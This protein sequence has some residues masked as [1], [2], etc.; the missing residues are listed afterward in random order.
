MA[1]AP[2]SSG[3]KLTLKLGPKS[4]AQ[5]PATPVESPKSKRKQAKK[6]QKDSPLPEPPVDATKPSKK[7]ARQDADEVDDDA[8][9]PPSQ[10]KKQVKGEPGG[11]F[12]IRV[13]TAPADKQEEKV[14]KIRLPPTRPQLL[15]VYTTHSGPVVP[16]REPGAGYDSEDEEVEKDPWVEHQFIVRMQ[17]GDDCEYL[18]R[19]VA[20]RSV[21]T[22]DCDVKFL[23]FDRDSGR[24]A[25]VSVRGNHYAAFLVD[26][27]C[28]IENHKSWDKKTFYKVADIHQM[29]I[30]TKRVASE[31]EARGAELPP[32]VSDDT[33]QYPHGIT[34]PMHWVRKRR[35]RK[36]VSHRTIEA[37]EEE[38]NRLLARD[39]EVE[40]EGGSTQ[41]VLF[42]ANA[43]ADSED[44]D[45]EGEVEETI[46]GEDE[47]DDLAALFTA[48]FERDGTEA[49]VAGAELLQSP[50]AMAPEAAE[51]ESGSD[52]GED[53][54]DDDSDDDV[55]DE[56]RAAAQEKAQSREEIDELTREIATI[57]AQ[58]RQ[59]MNENIKRK[60]QE[61]R[62]KLA[63]D[64]KLK[65]AAIGE[66]MDDDD[67]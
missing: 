15:R 67:D 52:S 4:A 44:E 37:I 5:P 65:Y 21:G 29:L 48:E 24:R 60:M 54:D 28:I 13:P 50:D 9:P 53:D 30:V 3:F 27:P 14:G 34:P 6:P 57:D 40:R 16:P 45:A 36:R 59:Q 43:R 62:T 51:E 18:R 8:T 49:M 39:A 12:K 42:D 17:P 1:D 31:A 41:A 35:F 47:E 32:G 19:A 56:Q 66:A 63:R 26:L 10:R 58:L 38:V 25:M 46:E 20:E 7:R 22:K 2:P 61:K 55:D 64:L 33:W 11:T 23:F